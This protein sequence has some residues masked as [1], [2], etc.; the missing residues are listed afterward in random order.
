MAFYRYVDSPA[1]AAAGK[2]TSCFMKCTK[3]IGAIQDLSVSTDVYSKEIY[4]YTDLY[5]QVNT[6]IRVPTCYGVFYD[7]EDKNRLQVHE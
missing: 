1:A 4:F 6:A 3:N 2:P 7:E 5:K